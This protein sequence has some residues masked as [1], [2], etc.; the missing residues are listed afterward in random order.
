RENSDGISVNFVVGDLAACPA[1][2]N[3]SAEVIVNLI[4]IDAGVETVHGDARVLVIILGT[5]F[6]AINDI[7][8]DNGAIIGPRD[9]HSIFEIPV[10]VIASQAEVIAVRAVTR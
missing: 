7:A 3:T 6:Q 1:E 9:E 10:Y 5:P 4:A 2:K 8:S